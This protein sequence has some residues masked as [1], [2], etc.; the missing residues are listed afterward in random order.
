MFDAPFHDAKIVVESF[1]G[2]S[3]RPGQPRARR[4]LRIETR[5]IRFDVEKRLDVFVALDAELPGRN[6]CVPE[7]ARQGGVVGKF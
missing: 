2:R 7:T 4:R 1:V 3:T 6:V 5:C